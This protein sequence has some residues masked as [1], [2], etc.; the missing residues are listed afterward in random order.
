MKL[1]RPIIL[2][3]V[4]IAVGSLATL[5][6]SLHERLVAVVGGFGIGAIGAALIVGTMIANRPVHAAPPPPPPQQVTIH[7]PGQRRL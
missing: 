2:G 4:L 3:E 1:P 7:A 5:A 6:A